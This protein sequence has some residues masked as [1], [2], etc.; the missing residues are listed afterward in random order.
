M[1]I[2]D[3]M[4]TQE[5]WKSAA[6]MGWKQLCLTG[7]I[8]S[9]IV[10]AHAQ[11]PAVASAE[12]KPSAKVF[13]VAKPIQPAPYL[14]PMKPLVHL[15]DLK[16]KHKGEVNWTELVVYDKNN[17]A[18]VTSAGPGSKLPRQLHSDA[19]EY[20]V[21]LEGRIRFEVEDPPGEFQTFEAGKGDLVLAPERHLFSLQVIGSE[22]AIRLAVTLPDTSAIYETKPEH[23]E[24]G[25]EYIPVTLFTG[26]NPDD[27]PNHGKPDRLFFNIDALQKEHPVHR[28]WS[29]LAVRKNR[30][31]ANIICGYAADVKHIAGDLGHYHPDF[32]EIW[33]IMRG[34][35]SFTI[36]GLKPFV[37][38]EGDIVYAPAKRWHLIEAAGEGMSCRLAMTPYPDGNHLYQPRQ[39]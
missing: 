1:S 13:Y 26:N 23:A 9:F 36:E 5:S 39:Q 28:S 6:R 32:A 24:K 20:W 25:M 27:V 2:L 4:K 34:Q 19:P 10:A 35:Q 12:Q 38:S 15:A 30:A 29:D 16:N 21:V 37:A 22:P 18:E 14:S 3:N 7:L 11:T 33:T 31:H 8:A 17:R